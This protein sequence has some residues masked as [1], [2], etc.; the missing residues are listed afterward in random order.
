M[1]GDAHEAIHLAGPLLAWLASLF[2]P[3]ALDL[4]IP[5]AFL[6]YGAAMLLA[7]RSGV[8]TMPR[9]RLETGDIPVLVWRIVAL[10]L[11]ASAIVD[12]AVALAFLADLSHW[13]AWI[14]SIGSAGMLLTVGGLALSR[15]LANGRERSA[16]NRQEMPLREVDP[17]ADADM[18]ARLERLLSEQK[19]F[20]DPDLTLGRLS[21]RMG[22]PAKQL[23]IAINRSTGAN[24]SRYVNRFRIERACDRLLAG[25]TVTATMLSCGFNTRSN[26]NR[27]FRRITGKSPVN[28]REAARKR[29]PQPS[30]EGPASGGSATNGD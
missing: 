20:L 25:E 27:E 13:R 1:A 14:V 3:G 4:L 17:V 16:E 21:R 11:V 2:L 10:T 15:S 22:V 23:S 30:R 24:V 12:A 18:M 7:L 8:D 26:F 19:L 29:R 28:W 5:L 9:I 6:G